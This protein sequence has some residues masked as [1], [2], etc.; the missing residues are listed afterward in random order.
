LRTVKKSVAKQ[1]KANVP[2]FTPQNF[3]GCH[4]L[5]IDNFDGIFC[6]VFAN[7]GAT[8]FFGTTPR[9][10]GCYHQMVFAE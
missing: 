3:A 8:S 2:K 6:S 10:S 7:I 5:L 9:S 1:I 4:S